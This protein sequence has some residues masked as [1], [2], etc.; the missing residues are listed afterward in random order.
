MRELGP[1]RVGAALAGELGLGDPEP[2]R[3]REAGEREDLGE[4]DVVVPVVVRGVGFR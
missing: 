2:A 1:H 4:V 3:R